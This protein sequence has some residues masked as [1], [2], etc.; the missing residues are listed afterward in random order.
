MFGNDVSQAAREHA[1]S[2]W[3]R[4]C[5]GVVSNSTYRPVAN[6]AADPLNAFEM[7]SGVWLDLAP[8]AVIHSHDATT[9]KG[10]NGRARPRHPHHPSRADMQSQIAAGIPFGIVSTDGEAAS[11]LLWWGDHVLDEALIGRSFVPG[12][13]DCYALVRAWCRQRRGV[14]LPDFARD[15]AWW[16][17]GENM[18]VEHFRDAGFVLLDGDNPKPGDVF[19]SRAGSRVPSHSGVLDENGL[20]LHHLDGCLSCHDV[21][22]RWRARIT[23]WVRY[24]T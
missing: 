21:P 6:V 16:T 15:D 4:E 7:P 24:A 18:L 8:E 13:R 12:I 19:F 2:E 3:P 9:V 11:E 1:L 5:C 14:T 22:G 23:H 10:E 20:I 17:A